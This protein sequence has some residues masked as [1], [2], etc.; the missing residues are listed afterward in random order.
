MHET[1]ATTA[2]DDAVDS[3]TET[4]EPWDSNDQGTS[5]K[6]LFLTKSVG[7]SFFQSRRCSRTKPLKKRCDL[8][9]TLLEL[10]PQNV[11]GNFRFNDLEGLRDPIADT[12]KSANLSQQTSITLAWPSQNEQPQNQEIL[13]EG[14]A[15]HAI[16]R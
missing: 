8:F 3:A 11:F 15:I 16:L 2:S 9:Q 7:S 4:A 5:C 1:Q 6:C 13:W 10:N 14:A 12:K